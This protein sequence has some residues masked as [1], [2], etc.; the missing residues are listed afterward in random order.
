LKKS[1]FSLPY[2]GL[3]V[4]AVL[5][6]SAISLLILSGF[7][8]FSNIKLTQTIDEMRNT[9][10]TNRAELIV[11]ENKVETTRNDI[12]DMLAHE[13][14][15]KEETKRIRLEALQLERDWETVKIYKKR[16]EDSGSQIEELRR[17]IR[18][19]DR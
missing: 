15:L 7:H 3:I 18:E 6:L 11:L 12:E 13:S 5:F 19:L 1:I 16:I 2:V 9:Y 17:R 8:Y 10:A 14:N 4:K